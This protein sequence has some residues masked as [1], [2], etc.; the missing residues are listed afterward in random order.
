MSYGG[1][2]VTDLKSKGYPAIV[3]TGNSE[4]SVPPV[5]FD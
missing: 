1:E 3:D 5:I 4:L 2:Y